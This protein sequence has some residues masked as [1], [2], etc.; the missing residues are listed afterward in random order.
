LHPPK[1]RV[2]ARLPAMAVDLATEMPAAYSGF[3]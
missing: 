2:G 3:W 1:P